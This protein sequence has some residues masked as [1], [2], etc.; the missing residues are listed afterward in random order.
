MTGDVLQSFC[1]F[2]CVLSILTESRKRVRTIPN[3]GFECNLADRMYRNVLT[4]HRFQ[5]ALPLACHT[6]M[7]K[8]LF[9][10]ESVW[11]RG[12]QN[13][14]CGNFF[15]LLHIS[16][17]CWIFETLRPWLDVLSHA[18][19][20]IHMEHM[21]LLQS[22]YRPTLVGTLVSL[23][24]WV[25]HLPPPSSSNFAH[26]GCNCGLL[27]ERFSPFRTVGVTFFFTVGKIKE[28]KTFWLPSPNISGNSTTQAIESASKDHT[29]VVQNMLDNK[30]GANGSKRRFSRA[31]QLF[32]VTTIYVFFGWILMLTVHSCPFPA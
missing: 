29:T 31:M 22:F 24:F 17:D 6:S 13:S 18:H 9:S 23:L 3:L 5:V 28:N 14:S 25:K 20:Y 11:Q 16:F 15:W 10:V 7:K 2:W 12:G 8:L 19:T 4:L 26:Q 27:P 32:F 21:V 1:L 30:A